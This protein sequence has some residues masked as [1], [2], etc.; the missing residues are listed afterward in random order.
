MPIGDP[1]MPAL[2]SLPS[3]TADRLDRRKSILDQLDQQFEAVRAS[4][5]VERL[6]GFQQ[7]AFDMLC[8][9]K[10]RDAFDLSGES[11]ATRTVTVGISG[12]PRCWWHVACWNIV[13]RSSACTRTF[14][15]TTGMPTTCMRTTSAC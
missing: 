13:F 7:R 15:S 12:D 14:T 9:S 6:D 10:T 3:M 5:A 2:D 1:Q 4:V 11:K 8:S